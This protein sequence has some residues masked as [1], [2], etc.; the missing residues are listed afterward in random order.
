M[1]VSYDDFITNMYDKTDWYCVVR[2]VRE[3]GDK[4]FFVYRFF[5]RE[6]GECFSLKI[7]EIDNIVL[8]ILLGDSI[9]QVYSIETEVVN[10]HRFLKDFLAD[11]PSSLA[12]E[13]VTDIE[14]YWSNA[15]DY[16][17][18]GSCYNPSEV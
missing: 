2:T 8:T 18:V 5:L 13:E 3:N 14:S 7:R 6:E 17:F 16:Q 15:I 9:E 11:L 1:N 12:D 4:K 10:A